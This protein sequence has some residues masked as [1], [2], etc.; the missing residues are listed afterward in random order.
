MRHH[1]H[2][3]L[4]VWSP[5]CGPLTSHFYVRVS[6]LGLPSCSQLQCTWG[7]RP[8]VLRGL[9]YTC[10]SPAFWGQAVDVYLQHSWFTDRSRTQTSNWDSGV[11]EADRFARAHGMGRRCDETSDSD[12]KLLGLAARRWQLQPHTPLGR[13][14]VQ[15]GALR[16]A[17]ALLEG[18]CVH[19]DRE[20]GLQ[21]RGWQ[22][23]G[24]A[25]CTMM[26]NARCGQNQ[27]E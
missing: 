9:M 24:P 23:T 26:T 11:V 18:G 13:S 4:A 7:L 21:G 2:M 10:T 22:A 3:E 19:D 6:T 25:Q 1:A 5:Q 16:D 12:V 20:G 27:E 14:A 17:V 15:R 8:V